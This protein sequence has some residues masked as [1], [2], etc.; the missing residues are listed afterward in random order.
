MWMT[1]EN[2]MSDTY[3]TSDGWYMPLPSMYR[4]TCLRLHP[5]FPPHGL[6]RVV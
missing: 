4:F 5:V 3:L 2:V 1:S 6:R